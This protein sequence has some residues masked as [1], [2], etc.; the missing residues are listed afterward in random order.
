MKPR[1]SPSHPRVH[2]DGFSLVELL[3]VMALLAV[4][5]VLV[6]PSIRGVSSSTELT[7]SAASVV[8]S[9]NLARQTALS[10]NRPVEVRFYQVPSSTD[11]TEAFR[12]MASY[13]LG[14]NQTN[15][16]GRPVWL[17]SG[18]VLSDTAPFGTLLE[19]L[20]GGSSTLPSLGPTTYS[21]RSLIFRPDG[22]VALP[23]TSP[24]DGGDTW[25]VMLFNTSR[26]PTGSTPPA[27][28][29]TIQL[30]PETGRTRVFQPGAR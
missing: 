30:L 5:A 2:P 12:A 24:S 25:H 16:I 15:P 8:D 3:T 23:N 6:L 19:G 4:L 13:V 17:R 1:R 9:L 28:H 20:P 21:Y 7:I 27:N 18:V 26:P 29:V 14:N 22:S 11:T 10:V